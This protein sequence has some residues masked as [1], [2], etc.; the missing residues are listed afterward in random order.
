VRAK[1][2]IAACAAAGCSSGSGSGGSSDSKAATATSAAAFGGMNAL[3][4]AAKKEGHL[5]PGTAVQVALP[6]A[7]VLVAPRRPSQSPNRSE[8]PVA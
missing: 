2:A 3:V 1:K 4:A 6:A 8:V 5:I 7:P